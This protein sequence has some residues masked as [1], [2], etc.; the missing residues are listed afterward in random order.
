MHEKNVVE[1]KY[2]S[3]KYYD[4]KINPQPFKLGDQ[5]FFIIYYYLLKG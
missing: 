4:R 3:K 1:V 2:K 5:V